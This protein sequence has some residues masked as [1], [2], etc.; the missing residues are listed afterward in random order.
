MLIAPL[1]LFTARLTLRRPA[2]ADAAQMFSYAGDQ[3]ATRYMSWPVHRTLDDTRRYVEFALDAWRS[4][5]VGAYLIELGGEVIG[6]TGLDPTEEGAT[7]GYILVRGAWGRGYA[8]E[9]CRAMLELGRSIGLEPIEAMCHVDHL[10]SARVL[11]KAGMSYEGVLRSHILF[12]NL[13]AAPQDVR[14]YAWRGHLG[15]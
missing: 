10:P 9:A 13:A 5:G 11:E 1:R 3:H 2:L 6:S 12:P 14:R 8:T 15:E 7:T 4:A